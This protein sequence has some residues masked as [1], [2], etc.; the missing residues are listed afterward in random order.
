[1]KMNGFSS[2]AGHYAPPGNLYRERRNT[3]PN[4]GNS[5][6]KIKL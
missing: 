2:P 1:M 4:A 3:A 6:L 5:P